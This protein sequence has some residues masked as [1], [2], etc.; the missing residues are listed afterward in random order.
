MQYVEQSHKD[1]R[2]FTLNSDFTRDQF[3]VISESEIEFGP[4]HI[5]FGIL[6]ESHFV[7][8]SEE[9]GAV[10]EI[11]ACTEA[12]GLE[13]EPTLLTAIGDANKTAKLDGWHYTFHHE[14]TNMNVGEVRLSA[15][16]SKRPHPY[17]YYLEHAFPTST[18]SHPAP[19]TE[20]YITTTRDILIETVHTYPEHDAMVFTVSQFKKY[21][22]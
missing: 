13:T 4:V 11:C 2:L 21:H 1:L 15:L 10:S 6:A 16:Q 12:P 22:D 14:I 18:P 3:N 5:H 19:L 8:L 9:R 7:V 17:S 20:I